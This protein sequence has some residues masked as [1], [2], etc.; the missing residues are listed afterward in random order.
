MLVGVTL[1]QRSDLP[2]QLGVEFAEPS[3][4]VADAIEVDSTCATSVDGVFAAGD[5]T[6]RMPSVASSIAAGSMAAAGIVHSLM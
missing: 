1:H 6:T 5:A 4:V 3:K 2:A